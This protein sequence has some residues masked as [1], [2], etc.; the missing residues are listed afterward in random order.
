MNEKSAAGE[1]LSLGRWHSLVQAAQQG[2]P[3]ARKKVDGPQETT[4]LETE[5]DDFAPEPLLKT[6]EIK[7]TTE[8]HIE[9]REP[10]DKLEPESEEPVVLTV[11]DLNSAIRSSLEKEFNFLWVQGEISN[12]KAHTS[13]H[14]YLALK[15][16]RSQIQAVMF[17]QFNTRLKFKPQ[18]GMEVL[19]R[20]R[21][22][23]YEP[24][25]NYQIFIEHMEPVGEGALRLAFEQLKSKLQ[26]EGLFE[27]SRKRPLP[28]FPQHIG[29][30]TSPTGAAIRDMINVLTRRYRGARIT[31]FP[32]RVQ[33]ESAKHEIVEALSKVTLYSD[34]DVVIVGRGGGSAEDLWAFNEEIVARAVAA[35]P[36]PVISAVGH[37]V[38][39]TICDFVADLRAPTPSAAAE[40]VVK[41]SV[42]LQQSIF[43]MRQRLIRCMSGVLELKTRELAH[44]RARLSDPVRRLQ[45][46]MLKN[47]ELFSRLHRSMRDALESARF[48]V[49]HLTAR[50]VDPRKILERLRSELNALYRQLKQAQHH[51]LKHRR[52]LLGQWTLSLHQLSPLAT[53]ARGYALVTGPDGKLIKDVAQT[54]EGT[55]LEIQ[56]AKGKLQARV[57]KVLSTVPAQ[58]KKESEGD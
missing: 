55:T 14:Y 9:V 28:S 18:D 53:V 48:E 15:D 38:D 47:D 52:S 43:S 23:V 46:L 22:T 19:V 34:M 51:D 5:A 1:Q 20:G 29:I 27:V 10:V 12:F 35:C 7:V 33:G 3:P 44:L 25:G 58:T 2:S 4:S 49:R 32:C 39:F 37:E 30:V 6:T 17:R 45:D 50:L 42:E 26:Q 21:V 11:S 57:E 24:R 16:S 54:K 56:L 31:L 40:I 41:N 36:V 8:T 13:G